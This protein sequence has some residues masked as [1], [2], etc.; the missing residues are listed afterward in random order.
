[1]VLSGTESALGAAL[2]LDRVEHAVAVKRARERVLE[3]VHACITRVETCLF[4]AAYRSSVVKDL[5]H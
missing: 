4:I 2:R 1:M 3:A 5:P